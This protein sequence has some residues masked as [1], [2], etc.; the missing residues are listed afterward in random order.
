MPMLLYHLPCLV[1]APANFVSQFLVTGEHIGPQLLEAGE[2]I[3]PQLIRIRPRLLETGN[4]IRPQL[5][6]I[7]PRLLEAGGHVRP[8]ALYR[9]GQV[10]DLGEQAAQTEY[11]FTGEYCHRHDD[12]EANGAGR[13]KRSI[14]NNGRRGFHKSLR[15]GSAPAV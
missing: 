9:L 14:G 4:H 3:G 10:A 13:D 15:P 1:V 11:D 5:I 12:A 7:G 2:H 6:R 8:Q